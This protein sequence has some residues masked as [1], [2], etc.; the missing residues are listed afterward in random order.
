MSAL[1]LIVTAFYDIGRGQWQHF[2]RSTERYFQCFERLC[3]HENDI[4]VFSQ[5]EF[6]E[7]FE[8]LQRRKPN[9]TVVYRDIFSEHAELLERIRSI[10]QDPAFR[11]GIGPIESPEYNSAEYVL[12]NYLKSEF[13]C[14]AIASGRHAAEQVAWIDF[15][16]VRKPR[17]VARSGR[18]ISPWKR[19][20]HVFA[21]RPLSPAIEILPTIQTNTVYIQGCHLVA[22][23]DEWPF[24]KAC[25]QEALQT[26]LAQ[27]WVDDDQ[28]LLMMSALRHPERFTVH[29]AVAERRL[30]W[31]F[32]LR[33]FNEAEAQASLWDRLRTSCRLLA[34]RLRTRSAP[35]R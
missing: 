33:R 24:F 28:T 26:L 14:Q 8:A 18:W 35:A 30:D 3:L 13:C 16:Y 6:R 27:G 19:G 12:V 21:L 9:L 10:Q 23:R 7:R 34:H 11:A 32:L 29:E 17:Q 1:P 15:G 22:H 20:I 25:M 4:V 31:F 5:P 2:Q